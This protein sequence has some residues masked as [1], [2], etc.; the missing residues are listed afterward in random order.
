MGLRWLYNTVSNIYEC[1]RWRREVVKLRTEA[2]I[3]DADTQLPELA[4]ADAARPLCHRM[5]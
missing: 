2:M 1:R 5:L 3:Q 4:A